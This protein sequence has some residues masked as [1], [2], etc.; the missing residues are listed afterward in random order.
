[1]PDGC[2]GDGSWLELAGGWALAVRQPSFKVMNQRAIVGGCPLRLDGAHSSQRT[3]KFLWRIGDLD[4][5]ALPERTGDLFLVIV[6]MLP[7]IETARDSD[8]P[9]TVLQ[10]GYQRACAAMADD[11]VGA[12]KQVLNGFERESLDC[13]DFGRPTAAIASLQYD[14]FSD[15]SGTDTGFDK[16]DQPGEGQCRPD[17]GEQ[18]GFFI[19]PRFLYSPERVEDSRTFLMTC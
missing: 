9:A 10:C 8:H 6:V 2:Q 7:Q 13:L 11:Y 5:S 14:L 16:V 17:G 12:A 3:C 1:M 15:R 19:R 4:K 18:Q